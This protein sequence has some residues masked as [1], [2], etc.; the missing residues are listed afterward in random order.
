MSSRYIDYV[1]GELNRHPYTFMCLR[2]SRRSNDETDFSKQEGI[3]A[4]KG[5]DVTP[6]VPYLQDLL[7]SITEFDAVAAARFGQDRSRILPTIGK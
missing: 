3:R 5:E 1:S 6:G 2:K 7:S 4:I